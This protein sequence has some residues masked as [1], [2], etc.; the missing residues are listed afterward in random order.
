M[1]ILLAGPYLA[2]AAVIVWAYRL[3]RAAAAEHR[4]V[5][6]AFTRAATEAM[7]FQRSACEFRVNPCS[8]LAPVRDGNTVSR[9]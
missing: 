6:D 8:G 3:E 2:L 9:P 4:R 1:S 5:T 7:E